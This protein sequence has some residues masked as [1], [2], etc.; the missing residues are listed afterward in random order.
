M[1]RCRIA[2]R[3]GRRTRKRQRDRA[4]VQNPK[5]LPR[6][7]Q[8]I[9]LI[10]ARIA[11]NRLPRSACGTLHSTP[12]GVREGK[13]ARGAGISRRGEVS[14]RKM[15]RR[16]STMSESLFSRK[17]RPGNDADSSG[18]PSQ[19]C[20]QAFLKRVL[21]FGNGD[22]RIDQRCAMVCEPMQRPGD[23]R[24]RVTSDRGENIVRRQQEPGLWVLPALTYRSVLCYHSQCDFY[25]RGQ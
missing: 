20:R 19:S 21:A 4:I 13:V 1:H 15:G 10:E 9:V 5:L 18:S 17:N 16:N 25:L 8:L 11:A 6:C 23:P 7:R 24:V 14:V 2:L 3:Q 12:L 22:A